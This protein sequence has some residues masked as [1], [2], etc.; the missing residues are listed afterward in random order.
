[1][2]LSR[3]LCQTGRVLE[4]VVNLC[5][6]FCLIPCCDQRIKG[7]ISYIWQYPKIYGGVWKWGVLFGCKRS[8]EGI[9]GHLILIH[10]HTVIHIILLCSLKIRPAR[11]CCTC[12][13]PWFWCGIWL[14]GWGASFVFGAARFEHRVAT[15]SVF[16][17]KKSVQIPPAWER[18]GSLPSLR[19]NTAT[20]GGVDLI[21]GAQVSP[22]ITN[23]NS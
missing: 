9:K 13:W 22:I 8:L 10:H 5:V 23:P 2:N 20:L 16:W 17:R 1:M 15:Y 12:W 11:T 21:V 3:K 19:V 14:R 18:H 7:D 4:T 6:V